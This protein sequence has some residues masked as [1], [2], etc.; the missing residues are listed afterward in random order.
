METETIIR[1]VSET[2]TDCD[3]TGL[4][5]PHGDLD[6]PCGICGG[7]GVIRRPQQV[8]RPVTT[9]T[10]AASPPSTSAPAVNPAAGAPSTTAT[11]VVF[12]NPSE[13]VTLMP[14]ASVPA[15][16]LWFV[17]PSGGFTKVGGSNE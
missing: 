5:G 6:V 8:T 9:L 10:V 13:R 4:K 11:H 17:G 7:K 2:C 15:G 1:N 14:L 16:E 12:H 3:G